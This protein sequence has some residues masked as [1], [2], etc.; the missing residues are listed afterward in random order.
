MTRRRQ[1]LTFQVRDGSC[2]CPRPYGYGKRCSRCG[3]WA[4]VPPG[5][6]YRTTYAYRAGRLPADDVDPA[7]DDAVRAYED[8]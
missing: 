3:G 4:D 5:Y 7:F 6:E 2:D 1:A 8:G